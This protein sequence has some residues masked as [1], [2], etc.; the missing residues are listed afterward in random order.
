MASNGLTV[1]VGPADDVVTVVIAED[2]ASGFDSIPL[3]GITRSD[4]AELAEAKQVK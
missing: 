4:H 3:H 2:V 1:V